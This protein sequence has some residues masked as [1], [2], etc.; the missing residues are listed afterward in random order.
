MIYLI[1]I[2]TP[3]TGDIVKTL[4]A[5]DE[6]LICGE[7]Y[8][9]RDAAHKRMVEGLQNGIPLPFDARDSVIYYAGPAP[10]RTGQIIGSCGPTTSGRMD[11]Y[12][13]ALIKSGVTGMIGKG[14]RSGEVIAAMRELGAVYFAAIGGAGALISKTVTK[15][16]PVAYEDLGAEAVRKLTVVDFPAIVVIDCFG[17]NLYENKEEKTMTQ[18]TKDMIIMDVLNLDRGTARFF[19]EMGMHCLGCPSAS[20]ESIEQ[21][22]EVHGEDADALVVK[23]NAYLA[24]NE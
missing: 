14:E 6:V 7:I 18:I 23:I 19:L 20:G 11:K 9:A 16:E 5:G 17:N 22:C 12:A 10:A 3:L 21:A 13:P 1:R 24:G 8:T 4:R 2:Q 15:V